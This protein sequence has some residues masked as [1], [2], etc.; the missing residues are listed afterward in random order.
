VVGS[1][2]AAIYSVSR[3]FAEVSDLTGGEAAARA[4]LDE[5]ARRSGGRHFTLDKT[6]E[7]RDF[8]M[9][10]GADFRTSFVVGFQLQS[11]SG[12]YRQIEVQIQHPELQFLWARHRPAYTVEK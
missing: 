2:E 12:P 7:V 11:D 6:I 5:I 1:T 3:N 4:G 8:G 9:R 10:F